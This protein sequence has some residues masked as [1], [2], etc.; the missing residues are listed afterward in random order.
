MSKYIIV[1]PVYNEAKYIG[2]TIEGVIAQSVK[3]QLWVIVD[4][5]STD[6]TADIIKE[7]AQKHEWIR[8]IYRPKVAGQTYFGS[9][10][11]AIM[12]G[13]DQVKDL[14]FGNIAILDADI[15]LPP[16]YYENVFE[17]FEQDPKLGI[18][19]GIYENLINGTLRR[20]LNDRRSTPK[21]IMV[22]RREVFEQIGG[23]LPLPDGGEDTAAC[24]MA[25]MKGW[26]TWSFPDIKVVHHRSTGLG[27][28]SSVLRARFGQGKNEYGLGSHPLFV[29]LKSIRRCVKEKPFIVSGLA[30]FVGYIYVCVK[31]PPRQ[32][33][34]EVMRFYRK[35]QVKRILCLNKI[36]HQP[37]T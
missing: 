20:V 1:T 10:V 4:D 6:E 27:D 8:Y 35:E 28:A 3:P 19:S 23:F 16:T 34:A 36:G 12:A 13:Y 32:V 11:H 24:I 33:P 37:L 17:C 14:S 5:G 7:Y 2:A 9:N 31:R 15:S 22:F 18:A 30:R 25:R 29:F 26:Q 21:A